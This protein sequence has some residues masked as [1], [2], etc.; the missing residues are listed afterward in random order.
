MKSTYCP[1]LLTG[2]SN[3]KYGFMLFWRG[4]L[5]N[6]R[7]RPLNGRTREETHMECWRAGMA[8]T[9]N[10]EL[11]PPVIYSGNDE[12]LIGLTGETVSKIKRLYDI[13]TNELNE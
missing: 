8:H 9:L 3:T 11:P 12:A 1:L 7:I 2:A 10:A 6:R 13:L 5:K 4:L